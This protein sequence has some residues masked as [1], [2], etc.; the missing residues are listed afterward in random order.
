[1]GSRA[2]AVWEGGGHWNWREDD[3]E[4]FVGGC[5]DCWVW[6]Q[7]ERESERN[8]CV[9]VE[10]H[11]R[12]R[13]F[14]VL[15]CSRLRFFFSHSTPPPSR[16]HPLLFSS[17]HT[18]KEA[19]GYRLTLSPPSASEGVCVWESIRVPFP[20]PCKEKKGKREKGEGGR[21]RGGEEEKIEATKKTRKSRE[22]LDMS[23]PSLVFVRL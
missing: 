16:T 21:E 10:C 12:R 1:M 7:S 20:F 4:A 22:I 18:G 15:I 8:V 6:K 9:C 5:R 13:A 2:E 3:F 14:L 11:V 23:H 19:L 17:L